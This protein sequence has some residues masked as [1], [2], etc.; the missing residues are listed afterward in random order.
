ERRVG[1]S[2]RSDTEWNMAFRCHPGEAFCEYRAKSG[3]QSGS[4][5][6]LAIAREES[7]CV[8]SAP[9]RRMLSGSASKRNSFVN[10]PPSSFLQ[11]ILKKYNLA[12][13]KS[14]Y[15]PRVLA[16]SHGF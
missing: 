11:Q 2:P 12:C 14:N 15:S 13:I 16:N 9:V 8:F 4:R 7:R 3:P 6:S 10:Q 5:G 1:A